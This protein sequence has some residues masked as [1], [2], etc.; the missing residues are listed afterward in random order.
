MIEYERFRLGNGLTVLVTEDWSTPLVTLNLL[1]GV[2]ARDEREGL[3]G[4]AHLF[5]HLMFGGTPR[6]PSYDR[7]VEQMGGE[8]NAFTNNDYTNFYITVPA[9]MV[10][11]AM[12]LEADR[13]KGLDWSE[14]VLEVQK[15]V[16]TEEYRQRYENQPYGDLWLLL[17]PLCFRES[18]Y[19][20]CTIG[21]DIRDVS[22]AKMEDVRAFHDRF[23][24]PENMILAVAGGVKAE[25]VRRL[26]EKH[27]GDLEPHGKIE[28][29]VA[30][31]RRQYRREPLQK[32]A[33]RLEVEREVPENVFLKAYPMAGKR[34]RDF[35][36]WDLLSDVLSNGKSSRMYIDLVK[37]NP[38]FTELSAFVSGEY[39]EGLFVVKGMLNEGVAFEA[40]ERGVEEQLERLRNEELAARELEKVV[41]KYEATFA[42]SHYKAS[43]KAAN[44]CYYEW[45]GKTEWVNSEPEEYRKVTTSDLQ[46]VAREGLA[47]ERSN[48]IYYKKKS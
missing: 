27:F 33:R 12:W 4:F 15:K 11:R 19:S 13:L 29:G 5:E 44:L 1:C 42:F 14:G 3:T 28:G 9:T 35:V 16:V 24:G 40:A 26:A 23:Y 38:L 30:A 47:E 8:S 46:R 37:E 48:T 34:E 25:E 43:E 20:W 31:E 18:A 41:D 32:E 22:T 45:M 2:G 17:R 6:V 36:V 7:E 39:G 10:E 21:K